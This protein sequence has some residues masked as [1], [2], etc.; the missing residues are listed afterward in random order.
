MKMAF[1]SILTFLIFDGCIIAKNGSSTR[2]YDTESNRR[3]VNFVAKTKTKPKCDEKEIIFRWGTDSI[4]RIRI[5]CYFYECNNDFTLS[6]FWKNNETK[7]FYYG[8]YSIQGDTMFLHFD[9]NAIANYQPKIINTNPSKL[10]LLGN[11]AIHNVYLN[12][13]AREARRKQKN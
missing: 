8:K 1:Y 10:L 5:E 3:I 4:S 9:E 11:K 7:G 12:E 2:K 6:V 13:A